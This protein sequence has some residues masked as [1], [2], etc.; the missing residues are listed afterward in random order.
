MQLEWGV[1]VIYAAG[2]GIIANNA[3]GMGD[4]LL[5]IQ[6]KPKTTTK[7]PKPFKNNL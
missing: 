5:E 7:K 3:A 2:I 4:L 6:T 1:I